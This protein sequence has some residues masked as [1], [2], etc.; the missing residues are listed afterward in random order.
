[1]LR[2][3][4]SGLKWLRLNGMETLD[5]RA[6]WIRAHPWRLLA[7]PIALALIAIGLSIVVPTMADEGA[8]LLIG[9]GGVGGLAWSIIWLSSA[10]LDIRKSPV[11]GSIVFIWHAGIGSTILVVSLLF[12]YAYVVTAFGPR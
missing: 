5:R 11:I 6:A 3:V 9:A 12:L 10:Y 2:S 7:G 4:K 1:M 8:L